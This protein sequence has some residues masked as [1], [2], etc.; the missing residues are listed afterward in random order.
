MSPPI[1]ILKNVSCLCLDS[2]F[3]ERSPKIWPNRPTLVLLYLLRV[4]RSLR[5][6]CSLN[7]TISSH[8]TCQ[9]LISEPEGSSVIPSLHLAPVNCS[10]IH[11]KAVLPTVFQFTSTLVCW[12]S[13]VNV[14]RR[15]RVLSR[16]NLVWFSCWHRHSRWSGSTWSGFHR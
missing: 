14:R 10:S 7:S 9:W 16:L 1:L 12:T 4:F 15:T 11:R 6:C 3:T 13:L 2:I 5:H 8:Q